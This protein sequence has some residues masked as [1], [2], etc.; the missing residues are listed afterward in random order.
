MTN[1]DI[2]PVRIGK[3]LLPAILALA[4]PFAL[5][6]LAQVKNEDQS[7]IVV[8]LAPIAHP[9]STYALFTVVADLNHDG[10]QDVVIAH[11][12]GKVGVMLGNGDGTL[13]AE[14]TYATGTSFTASV[15]V[16][17]VNRDGKPDIVASNWGGEANG[18]ASV[19]V[20]I[21]NGDG[22]F[23]RAVAYDL[24]WGYDAQLAVA[25][26]D[27]D[28]KPDIVVLN[29][30]GNGTGDVG[31]LLGNGDGT[32]QRAAT[33]N[34]GGSQ[35]CSLAIGDL[36]GDGSQDLV[37][38][39]FRS[40]SVSVL[41]GNG[42]GT[43]QSPVVYSASYPCSSA[44][45][46]LNGDGKLDVVVTNYTS[47]T[48]GVLFG[49][50]DGTLQPIV[51]FS[52]GGVYPEQVVVG[53][54]N[55][56]GRPDLVVGNCG[57]PCGTD[58]VSD[59]A[60]LVGNGDG[61][62]QPPVTFPSGT[63]WLTSLAVADMDGD[64]WPDIVTASNSTSRVTVLPNNAGKPVASRT[65]LISSGSPSLV[66]QPV[67]FIA[68]ITATY[69]KIPDGDL[70]TFYDR[71]TTIGSSSTINGMATITTSALIG[72]AHPIKATYAG[73]GIFEPSTGAVNQVLELYAT[74][75]ALQSNL[76]PSAY[77]KTVTFTA[78][79]S[80]AGPDTPTGKV[81]FKD[82]TLGIGTAPLSGGVAV[83]HKSNL[84]AGTHSITA[85]YE[86]DSKS[87]KSTSPVVQQVVN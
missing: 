56:D 63:R 62:F 33:Y 72:K 36:N 18:D 75:T 81:A 29:G 13:Q 28:S 42:H 24:G 52:S 27:G 21:G 46:D 15:A 22:T 84:A 11:T 38:T 49:N 10:R 25:D 53:D 12:N 3:F 57:N 61:S 45:A 58:S 31:V 19:I 39:A 47:N 6:A 16:A 34:S 41:I 68:T 37:I 83:L 23:Q 69:G 17:D 80:S 66:G 54:V 65:K 14:T 48:V 9:V 85:I 32:F 51:T 73:D 71:G 76:N 35:P 86:G 4:I 5:T 2:R 74:A 30:N 59:V 26:V 64:G 70:V 67:T 78:T 82:G 87:G 7:Q 55:R 50:G 44:V 60:V 43:F 20:L 79:V 8:F 40:N 1:E 77:G